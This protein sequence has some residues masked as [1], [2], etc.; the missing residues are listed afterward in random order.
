MTMKDVI[1]G[2]EIRVIDSPGKQYFRFETLLQVRITGYLRKDCLNGDF[3]ALQ[4]AV[5]CLVD[6][7]HP[8]FGD[9]AH[10]HEAINQDLIG[11]QA[12]SRR[13]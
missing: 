9:K 2:A 3:G 6:L 10:D 7:A 5:R 13:R 8:S 12:T 11:G 4:E 1:N